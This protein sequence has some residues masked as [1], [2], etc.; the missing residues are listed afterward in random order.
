MP[1]IIF[2]DFSKESISCRTSHRLSS[3][4]HIYFNCRCSTC[5]LTY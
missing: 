3:R 1:E 2:K 5:C 4:Y